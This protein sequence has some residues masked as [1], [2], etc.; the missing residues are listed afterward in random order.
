[1]KGTPIVKRESTF[2]Q[3]TRNMFFG[4]YIYI[5]YLYDVQ[6]MDFFPFLGISGG[7]HS[8]GLQVKSGPYLNTK[9]FY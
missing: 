6:L 5:Y 2:G 9:F 3:L 7:P 1:M 4:L 8:I